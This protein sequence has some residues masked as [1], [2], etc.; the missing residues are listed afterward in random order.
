MLLKSQS[1]RKLSASEVRACRRENYFDPQLLPF[2]F[3]SPFFFNGFLASLTRFSFAEQKLLG[4]LS[5]S[6][7]KWSEVKCSEVGSG[8]GFLLKFSGQISFRFFVWSVLLNYAHSGMVWKI[9]SLGTSYT[10]MTKLSMTIKT[11]EVTSGTMDV[12]PHTGGL[13]FMG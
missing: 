3:S 7:I 6:R 10:K 8:S 4:K 13:G 12:S 9:S 2:P 5:E 1:C 11:D